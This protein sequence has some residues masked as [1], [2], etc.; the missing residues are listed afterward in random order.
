MSTRLSWQ[1]REWY[2]EEIWRC[3]VRMGALYEV[4]EEM[5]FLFMLMGK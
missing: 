2:T 4:D 3:E 1:W 5:D